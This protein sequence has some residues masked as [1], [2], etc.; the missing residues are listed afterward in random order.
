V[1]SEG[2]PED[3]AEGGRSSGRE[4]ESP[5]TLVFCSE[6]V[7]EGASLPKWRILYVVVGGYLPPS[8]A[9]FLFACWCAIGTLRAAASARVA[10]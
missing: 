4:G 7:L 3:L 1:S 8:V 6:D 9:G 10:E 5:L 2:D